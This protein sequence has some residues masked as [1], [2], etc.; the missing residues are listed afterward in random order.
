M[1]FTMKQCITVILLLIALSPH[2][3][4][5]QHPTCL[6]STSVGDIMV[7]LYPEKSTDHRCQLFKIRGCRII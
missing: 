4:A 1:R 6:I 5:Q 7:E 2:V 3:Q